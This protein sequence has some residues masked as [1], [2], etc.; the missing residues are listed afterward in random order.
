MNNQCNVFLD[1][2]GALCGKC[3]YRP[4]ERVWSGDVNSED[5]GIC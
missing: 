2:L 1:E 5:I 4:Q 3:G